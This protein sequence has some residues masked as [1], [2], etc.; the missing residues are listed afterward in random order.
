VEASGVNFYDVY[1]RSGT[2]IHHPSLPFTPGREAVGRIRA[3]GDEVDPNV[4]G[5]QVGSRVAWINVPESYA[6]QV[7]VPAAQALPIPGEFTAAQGLLFQGLTAQFLVTEY[8]NIR[9]GDRVLVHSAAG[10]VGTLLAQ[11]FKHLGAWV[12]GTTSSDA[13]AEAARR[14]GI[15]AVIN[16]GKEYQFLDE[17]MSLTEGKGVHLAIDGIGAATLESTL[18][19]LSKGGTAVSIGMVSGLAP[20]IQPQMLTNNCLRLAG[21]SVFSYTAEPAELQGRGREVVEGI[22]AGWL[23]L[24]QSTAFPLDRAADAHRAMESRGTPGKLYLTP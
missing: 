13:K 22:S 3:F 4:D 2:S 1:Q 10:G 11:W 24:D 7:V 16:Y 21:G 9:P 5:L 8:R 19:A 12:V 15:D 18:K 17:L 14:A 6:S 23:R 20:A